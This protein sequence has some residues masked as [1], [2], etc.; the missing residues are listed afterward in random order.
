[1]KSGKVI[2]EKIKAEGLSI[3]DLRRFSLVSSGA[4]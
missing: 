2:G 1:M 4:N 3:I